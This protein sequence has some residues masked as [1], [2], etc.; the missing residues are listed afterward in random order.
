MTVGEPAPDFALP[1]TD[2]K[3]HRLADHRGRRHV[4]IAWYPKADTPG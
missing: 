2:G 1:G 3:I 4:V